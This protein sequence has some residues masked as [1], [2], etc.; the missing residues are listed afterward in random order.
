MSDVKTETEICEYC[1]SL[2]RANE[3][4]EDEQ[5]YD[6]WCL[7]RGHCDECKKVVNLAVPDNP[8]NENEYSIFCGTCENTYRLLQEYRVDEPTSIGGHCPYCQSYNETEISDETPYVKTLPSNFVQK[9]TY[10]TDAS[11]LFEKNHAKLGLLLSKAAQLKQDF[12]VH[13]HTDLDRITITVDFD[14]PIRNEMVTYIAELDLQ[15]S[16]TGSVVVFIGKDVPSYLRVT[17]EY[18]EDSTVV[19]D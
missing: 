1:G 3:L 4:P 6:D 12:K 2:V 9:A 17:I 5:V 18:H 7:F 8:N 13:F 19:S 14:I 15:W 11:I 10:G 16:V